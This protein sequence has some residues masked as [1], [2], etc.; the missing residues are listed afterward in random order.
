MNEIDTDGAQEQTPAAA[1]TVQA[2]EQTDIADDQVQADTPVVADDNTAQVTPTDTES[3]D[4]DG[5]LGGKYKTKEDFEKAYRELQTLRQT[6]LE[7][8]AQLSQ[9]LNS[10]FG[11]LDEQ[12]AQQDGYEEEYEDKTAPSQLDSVNQKLA[13]MEFSMAYPD[14]D[15]KA[16][17]EVLT[18]DPVA[19]QIQDYSA[20]L[21]YAYAISKTNAQTKVVEA[22]QKQAQAA[23]VAK[24]AEKQAAQV[25]SVGKQSEPPKADPLS[26]SEIHSVMQNTKSFD[27]LL[28][29]K[30]PGIAS[31]FT[32]R[33]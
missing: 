3:S 31:Q 33:Q 2:Q 15:G 4:D 13:V 11:S 29:T 20:R 17:T 16:M 32:P 26:P 8:K 27:E 1:D 24:I 30:F 25:E 10:A 9:I 19:T 5:F 23:T 14:A 21:K 12:P 7:E 6:E 22:A 28:R 18:K